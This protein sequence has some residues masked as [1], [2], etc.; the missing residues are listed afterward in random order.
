MTQQHTPGQVTHSAFEPCPALSDVQK[1]APDLLKA[2]RARLDEW[3]STPSN[4]EKHEP[5]SVTLA[6][7]AITAA[8]KAALWGVV[9]FHHYAWRRLNSHLGVYAKP[10]IA[11]EDFVVAIIYSSN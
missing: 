1:A 11:R 10:L 7:A 3:H 5:Q 2:A 4:I 6:H 9:E 8:E